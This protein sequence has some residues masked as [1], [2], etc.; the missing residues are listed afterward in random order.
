MINVGEIAPFFVLKNQKGDEINSEVLLSTGKKILL[1]IYPKD[2][3]PGCTAQMCRVR[4]DFSEFTKLNVEVLGLNHGTP[5]E[6]IKFTSK[7]NLQFD[8]LVDSDRNLIKKL[9]ATKKFFNNEI[10]QRGAVLIGKNSQVLF[11]IKGQ[12]NNQEIIN[13]LKS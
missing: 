12:Q 8:I 11:S 7:Y 4:D 1:I 10:T 13:L 5:E 6:H 9:G 3:T 2:D